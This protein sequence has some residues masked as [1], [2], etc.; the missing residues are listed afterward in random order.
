[1]P[2]FLRL[3]TVP[4]PDLGAFSVAPLTLQRWLEYQADR[5]DQWLPESWRD[6]DALL[7]NTGRAASAAPLAPPGANWTY[8][9]ASEHGA[10]GISS[11]AVLALLQAITAVDRPLVEAHLR[12]RRAEAGEPELTP[13]EC[14]TLADVLL[15]QLAQLKATCIKAEGRGYGLFC[16]MRDTP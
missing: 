3:Y 16:V 14:A 13:D 7:G 8:P 2:L 12:R 15:R 9:D 4:D 6:L 5:H 10:Y 1:M 11:Q